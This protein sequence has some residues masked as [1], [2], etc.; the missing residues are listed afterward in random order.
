M[1]SNGDP[2]T[3]IRGAVMTVNKAKRK[4]IIKITVLAAAV[5]LL[6]V[7]FITRKT[8]EGQAYSRSTEEFYESSYLEYLEQKGFQGIMSQKT[9]NVD[10]SSFT[11]QPD[12]CKADVQR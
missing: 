8:E 12:W 4:K 3:I 9:V 7:Y 2:F 11:T 6:C 5:I 10:I 1:D